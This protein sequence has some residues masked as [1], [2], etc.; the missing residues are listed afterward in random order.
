MRFARASLFAVALIATPALACDLPAAGGATFALKTVKPV[1][2]DDVYLTSGFGIRLHP[3]LMVKK[4]HA[5]VDWAAPTG[6]P[7]I[8]AAAGRVIQAGTDGA[9]G[10]VVLM[11]HGGGW[12]TLYAQLSRFHV[13]AGAC[14]AAGETIADVGS[15]GLSAGPHLHF[16][17]RKDGTHLDPLSMRRTEAGS[18][19]H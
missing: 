16:E 11:D 12:Q 2:G 5:G 10:N 14:V 1:I 8:A 18:D 4:M 19:K 7:V 9:Y 15:T 3:L 13:Q 17:V 6:T